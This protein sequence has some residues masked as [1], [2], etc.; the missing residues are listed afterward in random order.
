MSGTHRKSVRARA[1]CRVDLGGGTLDIWPLGL[2]FAGA[3]T[4]NVA[5]DVI[6]EVT[7]SPREAGYRLRSESADVEL[8]TVEELA[9][10]RE[11]ALPGVVAAALGLPPVDIEVRSASPRGGGLGASSAVTV[12]LIAAGDRLLGRPPR[13]A[14][15]TARLARDLEARL[16]Q[17]PTGTQDH[18]PALLGGGLVVAFTPGGE[19]VRR[20]DVDLDALGRHLL[21]V[22]TGHSHFSAATNWTIIRRC[23]EADAEVRQLLQ[24]IAEV[25][26]ALPEPLERGDWREVGALV[27]REWQLRRRLADGV[28]VPVV[29]NLLAVA[30]AHGAWGGKACGAGGGGCVAILTPADRWESLGRALVAAGGELVAAL[31]TAT[32]LEVAANGAES[33]SGPEPD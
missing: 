8:A 18:Y 11:G 12:A 22:Y 6:V 28:T 25:A 27:D 15:G 33:V 5:L 17:L 3:Q 19:T 29:E 21:L 32:G 23:L 14:A 4:V 16:M 24:G 13:D 10:D 26:A 31:P 9:A 2:F 1:R 30:A 7:L 20:L